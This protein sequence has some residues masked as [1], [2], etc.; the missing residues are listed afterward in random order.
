MPT[1]LEGRVNCP[2]CG[3]PTLEKRGMYDIC[4]LCSWE[5]DGEDSHT[6]DEVHGGPNE[7]YSLRQARENFR[8]YRIVFPPDQDHRIG[9]PDSALE[10]EAKLQLMLAFGRALDAGENDRAACEQEI[11][12]LEAVLDEE[13]IRKVEE[14]EA[15]QRP[16]T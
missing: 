10:F 3:Y 11:L 15:G 14:F 12:R 16:P 5:D 2:C 4:V 7:L 13:T 6:Q 9:G 1:L 8:R